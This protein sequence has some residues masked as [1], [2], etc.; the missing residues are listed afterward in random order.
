MPVCLNLTDPNSEASKELSKARSHYSIK[1][2]EFEFKVYKDENIYKALKELFG[3]KC[4]Y[5]QG[6]TAGNASYDIEHFRPK[7]RVDIIQNSQTGSYS[8]GYYWLA[9]KW[10]NLL[11]SCQYCNRLKKHDG[12]PEA[13]GKGCYFGLSDESKRHH[14]ENDG[15]FDEEERVRLLLNPCIDKPKRHL[16]FKANGT[17][18]GKTIKGRTSIDVYGLKRKDLFDNRIKEMKRL[19]ERVTS[20]YTIIQRLLNSNQL[21]DEVALIH[22]EEIEKI[23]KEEKEKIKKNEIPYSA[24][25]RIRLAEILKELK[26]FKIDWSL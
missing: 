2:T 18:H 3:N 15:N 23:L 4:A 13:T 22:V 11:L 21:T 19:D 24:F 12:N 20:I 17:I 1:N 26:K 9:A 16:K 8:P 14:N 5:C 6:S 7:G 10:D 25:L